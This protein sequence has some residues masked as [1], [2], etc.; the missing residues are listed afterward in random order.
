MIGGY[1]V[2]FNYPL[3]SKLLHYSI[4]VLSIRMFY[5]EDNTERLF[6]Q[7]EYCGEAGPE[8]LNYRLR[9]TNVFL[10]AI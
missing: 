2:K 5:Y 9:F 3:L 10:R 8:S 4:A 7:G 1:F 6:W